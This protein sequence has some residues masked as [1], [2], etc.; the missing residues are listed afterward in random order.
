MEEV[1]AAGWVEFQPSAGGPNISELDTRAVFKMI[2]VNNSGNISR[3][4]QPG[5]FTVRG[6]NIKHNISRVLR[7]RKKSRLRVQRQHIKTGKGSGAKNND[8]ISRQVEN[9]ITRQHIQT[10]RGRHQQNATCPEM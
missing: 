4:V 6:V 7:C 9:P 2:D 5:L 1:E 8:N 10:G 3:Q